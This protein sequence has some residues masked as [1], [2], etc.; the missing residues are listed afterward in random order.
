MFKRDKRHFDCYRQEL[1][2]FCRVLEPS[3][4]SNSK[5]YNQEETP[6]PD[7]REIQQLLVLKLHHFFHPAV[8][9]PLFHVVRRKTQL[10]I[11]A[12]FC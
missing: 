3:C 9:S 1:Y 5:P 11:S 8:V 2:G 10:R 6:G 4:I 12:F 7:Y